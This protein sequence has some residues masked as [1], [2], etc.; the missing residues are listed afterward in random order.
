MGAILAAQA[1]SASRTSA[2]PSSQ[3]SVRPLNRTVSGLGD[4]CRSVKRK[5]VQLAA[6]T[7]QVWHT[8]G[9]TA[10]SPS[11]TLVQITRPSGDTVR[12]SHTPRARSGSGCL[13]PMDSTRIIDLSPESCCLQRR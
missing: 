11:A 9:E 8:S 1:A 12:Y 13:G 10:F 7:G 5:W 2:G 6:R 3:I 4:L